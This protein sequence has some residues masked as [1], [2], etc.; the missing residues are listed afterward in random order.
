MDMHIPHS[1]NQ[2]LAA[3]VEGLALHGLEI[4]P[5]Y[6]ELARRNAARAGVDAVVHEG[7]LR[8]PPP[9]LRELSFDQV[10][11]NPPYHRASSPASPDA[12]RDRAHREEASLDEWI[13]AGLRRLEPGG[14]MTVIH[15]A[16]RLGELLAA[17]DGR[18]GDV[19]V[20]PL[21]ARAGRAAGRVIVQARK[22]A[23]AP[24][25][26]L[27]PLVM[28]DGAVHLRDADD[29]S[30]AALAVLRDAGALNLSS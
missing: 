23:R 5:P 21:A 27:A 4:Q 9:K 19:R 6:A 14:R 25:T 15:R 12:G 30:S 2:E 26:L 10:I 8:R 3:R 1:R 13:D 20:L 18:A 16:E 11:A 29:F 24:L 28:H 7:D 17:F 22:G